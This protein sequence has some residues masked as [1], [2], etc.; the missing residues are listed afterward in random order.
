MNILITGGTGFIGRKLCQSLTNK[1]H[2]LSVLSRK[3]EKVPLLCGRQVRAIDNLDKLSE[4]DCFDAII[5]L[6]GEGIVNAR[7]SKKRKQILIDSRI[8]ITEQLTA[9]INRAQQKPSVLISGS[10]VG[11]YGN[12]GSILLTEQSKAIDDDFPHQLCTLWETSAQKAGNLGVRVCI[13]RAGLVIGNDGGFLAKMLPAF[14]LGIGGRIGN[15][16]QWMSWIHRS[17]LVQ[18]IEKML[19]STIMQGVYNGTAPTPVTNQEFTKC[20]ANQL[21]RPAIVPAPAFML[22]LLLGEMANLLLGGQRAIPARL[23]EINF[24]FQ[25]KTLDEA[26]NDVL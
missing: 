13:L 11:Y 15:G 14:K 17:D 18:I 20:L 5:N 7:W 19:N 22:S 3:P 25:F 16:Q 1:G 8:N 10:A 21:H 12:Q 23:Q 4:T 6:A 24:H 9:F 26:L 2:D